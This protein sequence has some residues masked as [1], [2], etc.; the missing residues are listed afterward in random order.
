MSYTV[1]APLTHIS[2]STLPVGA[3]RTSNVV[4]GGLVGGQVVSGR[5]IGGSIAQGALAGSALG[6]T[7]IVGG[8]V[9]TG[10]VVGGYGG[11]TTTTTG[12]ATSGLVSPAPIYNR[13]VVEEIPTESRIEYVPYEKREIIYEQV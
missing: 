11:L 5:T 9:G 6:G 4:S 12:L 2:G 3:V 7:R 13:A 10:A 1:G 8:T